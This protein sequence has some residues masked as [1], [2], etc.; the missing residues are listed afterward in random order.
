MKLIDLVKAYVEIYP[1]HPSAD[2]ERNRVGNMAIMEGDE[3]VGFID[4]RTGKV[5]W[6]YY[7]EENE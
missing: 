7:G 2:L 5:E 1:R 4:V 3:L 6:P